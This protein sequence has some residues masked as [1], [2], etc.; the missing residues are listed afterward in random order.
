MKWHCLI[1]GELTDKPIEAVWWHLRPLENP[2]IWRGFVIGTYRQFGLCSVITLLSPILNTIIHWKY[3]YHRLV[4]PPV[5]DARS[6]PVVSGEKEM[7]S[8]AA[9]CARATT[10]DLENETPTAQH[11]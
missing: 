9:S 1:C 6:T 2:S 3:R 8:A 4:I 10:K 11:E 7:K 5:P